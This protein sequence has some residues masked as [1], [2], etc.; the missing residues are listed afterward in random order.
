MIRMAHVHVLAECCSFVSANT[1]NPKSYVLHPLSVKYFFMQI[2][3]AER[4]LTS[5][6]IVI[7]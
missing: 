1:V 2:C 4:I 3:K 7:P 5:L 6:E